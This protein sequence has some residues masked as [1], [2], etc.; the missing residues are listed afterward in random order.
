VDVP[1]TEIMVLK[2]VFAAKE[3]TVAE[4]VDLM[5]DRDLKQIPVVES[6]DNHVPEGESISKKWL[7][8]C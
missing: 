2:P 3:C 5:R 7:S 6:K 4:A 8:T 1:V